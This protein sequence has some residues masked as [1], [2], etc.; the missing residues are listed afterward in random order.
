[1]SILPE[2]TAPERKVC[3]SPQ[4][5]GFFGFEALSGHLQSQDTMDGHDAPHLPRVLPGAS[6]RYHVV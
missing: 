2:V 1:M 5:S 6:V 4:M 3:L